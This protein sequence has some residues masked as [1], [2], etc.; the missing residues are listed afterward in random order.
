MIDTL[1]YENATE[2]IYDHT[3]NDEYWVEGRVVSS[4]TMYAEKAFF[5]FI[6][7]RLISP[8]KDNTWK[9]TYSILF[10]LYEKC[11]KIKLV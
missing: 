10:G 5:L 11:Q 9:H 7:L 3:T 1:V 8:W 2:D 6:L 4:K